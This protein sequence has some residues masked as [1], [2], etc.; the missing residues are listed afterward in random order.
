MVT[1]VASAMAERLKEDGN[2]CFKKERFGAA[3]DAYTE[4]IAL[5]PNVPAYWTNRALCH[6]KR[7]DWTKVEEDCRKAIQ[8]VHNSVKAHYMLGLAL[9]QKKEFT[10]G[11]KELQRALDL[12]R[13]SNP[14]GYMVEEIWEELSK[15]K[16]ME[17]ELVSAMRSWELNSLKETCEAALNQQRA[18][19]M[20]RTEESSDEAYT[21]HTERLKALERVFKKAAEEDKP[22]E[23]PDY[24]CCNITLEIF[25]DPVISPSG[26]TYERAA[27]LEHLK[28]VGKFDPITREKID[29]ANLVPNL[30]IKEAV[31]AYL[32]KHVWAYKMGC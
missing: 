13:C 31:A 12:G 3:I 21:A 16:Y 1:G 19:D 24:L 28:K 22:T 17:W 2:N 4:A 23:V 9:L 18:L 11:V 30:A 10:N 20:S 5:S 27:I 15:A 32:E 7:K 25:R 29:P 14:T 6:M 26:V 8:L